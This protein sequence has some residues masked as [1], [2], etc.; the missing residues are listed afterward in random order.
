V[1][2]RLHVGSG[3][4]YLRGYVNVD[5]V[6]PRTFLATEWP[7]LI[8]RYVTDEEHYYARH[9]DHACI[10]AFRDGPRFDSYLCDRFG[11]FAHLPCRD[12]EAEEILSRQVVEH[13]SCEEMT[14]AMR[15]A[16]RTLVP[17]GVLRLS[18]PDFDSSLRL[19][20]DTGD[21]VMLRNILG[22]RNSER[23]FHLVGYSLKTLRATV[24]RHG[25]EFISED[26]NPHCYPSICARWRK[27]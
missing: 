27:A 1:T 7:D 11:D 26:E 8:E 25:F 16:H 10:D 6:S 21:P 12:C 20:R 23:G 4:V 19:Y 13:L 15:E 2:V 14:A 18:V 22:P 3:S 5:I 9:D 24:E 17:H